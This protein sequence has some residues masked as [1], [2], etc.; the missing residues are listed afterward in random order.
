[1]TKKI[2]ITNNRPHKQIRHAYLILL[3]ILERGFKN[4]YKE[5]EYGEAGERES[6]S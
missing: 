4:N 2:A 3:S 6:Y 1:M 5:N